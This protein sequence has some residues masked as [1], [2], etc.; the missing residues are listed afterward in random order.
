MTI[1]YRTKSGH[2][3]YDR[4]SIRRILNVGKSKLQR[5]LKKLP[6]VGVVQHKNQYL[7]YEITLFQLMEK[8]L[9]ERI[10][11]NEI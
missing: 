4:F 2:K 5:E 7:Y 6:N 1:D 8:R 3:L 9:F 10:D 11:E